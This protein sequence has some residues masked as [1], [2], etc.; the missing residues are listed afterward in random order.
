MRVKFNADELLNGIESYKTFAKVMKL[1]RVLKRTDNNIRRYREISEINH[2]RT[3][4]RGFAERTA[5]GVQTRTVMQ[6]P[7]AFRA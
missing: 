1:I 7:G 4:K 2:V 6:E 5:V 3:V